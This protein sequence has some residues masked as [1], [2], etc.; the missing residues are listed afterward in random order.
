VKARA[1]RLRA[2]LRALDRD[3]RFAA[4][5][6]AALLLTMALPWYDKAV[7]ATGKPIQS[8]TIIGLAA[9]SFVEAAIFLVAVGVLVLVL[10][11]AEG[12]TFQ[13]PTDDGN[14]VFAAGVWAGALIFYRVLDHP[15]DV[16][17][18]WGLFVA[19]LVT[20]VLA[21]AGRRMHVAHR[22]KA[23]RTRRTRARPD[24]HQDATDLVTW[25][26]VPTSVLPAEGRIPKDRAVRREDARVD[27][28]DPPDAPRRPGNG[29][30]ARDRD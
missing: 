18:Q 5:A 4:G 28:A 12:A 2:A 23:P 3:Q 17:I 9:L 7:A 21:L 24:P 14:I 30:R 26:E 22:T 19:F 1:S 27:V 15:A 16:G 6:A 29:P 11:R 10:T 8:H 13:L 20:L 25:S